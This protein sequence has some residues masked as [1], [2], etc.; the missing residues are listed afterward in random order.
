MAPAPEVEVPSTNPLRENFE[1]FLQ[2][3]IS[4]ALDPNFLTE[5]T[6]E[7]GNYTEIVSQ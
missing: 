1:V 4:Q 7:N 2:T 6:N 5:I 3:L